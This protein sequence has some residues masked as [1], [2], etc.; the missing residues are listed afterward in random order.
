MNKPTDFDKPDKPLD[1]M[2]Y[3]DGYLD[4]VFNDD[5]MPDGAWFAMCTSTIAEH[6]GLDDGHEEFMSYLDWKS[7]QPNSG[8]TAG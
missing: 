4:F 3:L 8:V 7:K 1:D 2:D 6:W 5:D